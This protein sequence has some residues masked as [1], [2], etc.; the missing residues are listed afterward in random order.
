MTNELKPC[1]DLSEDDR[2]ASAELAADAMSELYDPVRVDVIPVLAAEFLVPESELGDA[3]V[4][5]GS[6][7]TGIVA[8][9]PATQLADRQTASL[10][11]ALRNL[12]SA[13]AGMLITQLRRQSSR[14]PRG[15]AIG[16]YIARIAVLG[17]LRGDGTADDLISM[18]VAS[19]PVVSLHVLK[20]NLRAV[21]FYRRHGFIERDASAEFLLMTR[22]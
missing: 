16:S 7:I 3:F 18:F 13:S 6:G 10:H 14:M 1:R 20:E 22:G 15:A 11:H 12:N 17:S 5:I 9:Y 2:F 4:S 19:R 8:H 21:G